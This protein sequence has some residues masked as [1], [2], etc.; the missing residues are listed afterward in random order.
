[1]FR[2]NLVTCVWPAG[3]LVWVKLL[4][5]RSPS[6]TELSSGKDSSFLL[7]QPV[8][9]TPSSEWIPMLLRRK[10]CKGWSHGRLLSPTNQT[11]VFQWMWTLESLLPLPVWIEKLIRIRPSWKLAI[12][13]VHLMSPT[14]LLLWF[15]NCPPPRSLI[16]LKHNSLNIHQF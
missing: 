2:S 1:M 4:C 3:P 13:K 16:P 15:Q 7:L 5:T 12:N 6:F 14:R 11:L 8:K 9:I 10:I